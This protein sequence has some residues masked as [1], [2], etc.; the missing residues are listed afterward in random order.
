MFCIGFSLKKIIKMDSISNML[1]SIQNCFVR[2]KQFLFLPNSTLTRNILDILYIEGFINGYPFV[3]KTSVRSAFSK[4]DVSIPDITEKTL[5]VYVGKNA[6]A[7]TQER[8]FK[9]LRMSKPGK[10][11]YVQAKNL[12]KVNR[13]LGIVIL[14]TTKGI[15]CDREARFLHLG[16]EV[17]CQIF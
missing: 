3:D 13:G 8:P 15:M 9:M 2:G 12:N 1:S 14:S 4:N 16:G 5:I 11:L 17:L 7:P 10:R 6:G